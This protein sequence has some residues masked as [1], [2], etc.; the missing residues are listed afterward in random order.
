MHTEHPKHRTLRSP[1]LS[2]IAKRVRLLAPKRPP[3]IEDSRRLKQQIHDFATGGVVLFWQRQGIYAG[4]G[5][6]CGFYYSWP[7]A[8]FCYLLVQTADLFDSAVCYRVINRTD[9]SL[10]YSHKL[11][12][13]L[14]LSNGLS[15]MSIATFTLLLARL[16]GPTEHF[17]SLFF[18]FAA[19]LFAAVNNHQIPQILALRLVSYG[20]LFIFIPAYDIVTHT[21]TFQ[22]KMWMHFATSLFVLYFVLECSTIFLRMYQR[23]LDQL[24]DL[25]TERDRARESYEI[26][27]QFVSVVSHELRTPLTSITGS[28]TLLRESDLS[29]NPESADRMLEIAHKNSKRLAKLINDLLD[30]QKMEARKMVYHLAP[31]D[32]QDLLDD[33][34]L[35]ITPYADQFDISVRTIPSDV[36]LT[37]RADHER[38]MQVL[39]NLLSNAV[40]FSHAGGYVE[41]GARLSDGCAVLEVR[42]YGIGIPDHSRHLVFDKFAQVDTSDSRNFDGTG[43]GLSIARQI[44]EDHGAS[45]DFESAP[46]EGTRFFATFPLC[47]TDPES[48]GQNDTKRQEIRYDDA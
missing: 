41:L 14:F 1:L 25:R 35:S 5:F 8:A 48:S 16:E 45:I 20:A 7:L 4:A 15:A 2:A 30:I 22:S 43:L 47:D 40:K 9:H 38:M 11:L 13:L 19:G 26:K 31:V 32:V 6:L 28:L 10:R 24:D 3:N 18:L 37:I 12:K 39:D 27:S 29:K 42:D 21:A 34:L 44:V 46:G 33:A 36:P 23:T 17:T